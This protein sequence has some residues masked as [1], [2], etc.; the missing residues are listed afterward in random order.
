M[1]LYD[2]RKEELVH[3][4]GDVPDY[5]GTGLRGHQ[6]SLNLGAHQDVHHP[7]VRYKDFV[8]E[9]DVYQYPGTPLEVVLICPKCHNALKV[10]AANK[11]IEFDAL[12]RA[13]M[14]GKLS[15]EVFKCSWESDPS[16]D[17]RRM[18]FGLGMCGW[19]VGVTNNVARDA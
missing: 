7:Q 8:I 9:C 1:P 6:S 19:R 16:K 10:S 12:D 17:G 4:A 15:I 11:Q 13:D 3:L 2:D 14:G 5:A 18:E